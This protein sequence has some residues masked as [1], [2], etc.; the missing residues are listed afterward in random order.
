MKINLHDF[1]HNSFV[2][3]V[4]RLVDLD[5]NKSICIMRK[6]F[7]IATVFKEIVYAC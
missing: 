2:V 1:T 4:Q 6:W 5:D 7:I 3:V